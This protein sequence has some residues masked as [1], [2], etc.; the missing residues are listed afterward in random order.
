MQADATAIIPHP[1]CPPGSFSQIL[2]CFFI[3][4]ICYK[5]PYSQHSRTL[6]IPF[7][8]ASIKKRSLLTQSGDIR[9]YSTVRT[10]YYV[11]FY[12]SA[13][14]IFATAASRNV[15]L[16]LQLSLHK[17]TNKFQKKTKNLIFYDH[18]TAPAT[19]SYPSLKNSF[20][21]CQG[22]PPLC[23]PPRTAQRLPDRIQTMFGRAV[24]IQLS[25]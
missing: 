21:G 8:D 22:H 6:L 23:L 3:S 25:V 4:L 5:R 2:P 17:K 10:D 11:I 19:S 14:S 7:G 20:N 12:D 13:R 9:C 16:T 1:S 18:C 24:F 15:F